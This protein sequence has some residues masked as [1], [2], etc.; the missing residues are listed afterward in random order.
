MSIGL[1]YPDPPPAE[2]GVEMSLGSLTDY[3]NAI[4]GDMGG[5]D[6]ANPIHNV[7]NSEDDFVNQDTEDS[8]IISKNVKTPSNKTSPKETSPKDKVETINPNALFQKGKVKNTGSGQGEGS[9]SGK[10]D[11]EDGGGGTGDDLTGSGTSFSLSGRSS[12]SLGLPSSRTN[13]VGSVIVTITVDQEGNVIRAIAGARGTTIDNKSLWRHCEY[14]A[15]QS[16]FTSNP[17][18]PFEQK[19][20]ITYKFQR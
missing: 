7:S 19:G 6:A 3:G 14:A 17:N 10:G 11:G 15:T 8:P 4:A 18:A 9:G 2:Q 20:T 13:E 1:K 5:V 16:K 12:K